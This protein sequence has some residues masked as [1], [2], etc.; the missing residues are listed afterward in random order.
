MVV[1]PVGP[2]PANPI[3]PASAVRRVARSRLHEEELSEPAGDAVDPDQERRRKRKP[4]SISTG[5]S[6]A[7]RCARG[8]LDAV[9]ALKLGG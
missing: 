5:P 1:P 8:V 4:P 9:T 6:A 3:S 7:G 2:L